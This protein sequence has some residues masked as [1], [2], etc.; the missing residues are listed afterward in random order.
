MG[1]RR[2]GEHRRGGLSDR[3]EGCSPNA[4]E[5]TRRPPPPPRPCGRHSTST[6]STRLAGVACRPRGPGR[7]GAA[8]VTFAAA[9]GARSTR[10]LAEAAAVAGHLETQTLA[11]CLGDAPFSTPPPLPS[12]CRT[13][14]RPADA[15]PGPRLIARPPFAIPNFDARRLPP[16][17]VPTLGTPPQPMARPACRQRLSPDT[18]PQRT[19]HHLLARHPATKPPWSIAPAAHPRSADLR[20]KIQWQHLPLPLP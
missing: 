8:A 3:R 18:P 17:L 10:R 12:E 13:Q 15:S 16:T 2:R 11:R 9:P 7:R 20:A 5:A 6:G 14:R 1:N 4:A 19:R